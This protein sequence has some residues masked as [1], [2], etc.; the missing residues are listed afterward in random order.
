MRLDR[1]TRGKLR[2]LD[3]NI[4]ERYVIMFRASKV[5]APAY[6]D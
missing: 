1:A 3:E 4:G 2:I 5:V 6:V